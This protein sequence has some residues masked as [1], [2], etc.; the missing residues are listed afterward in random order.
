[1]KRLLIWWEN[2]K[3]LTRTQRGLAGLRAYVGRP[4]MNA[5]ATM[6]PTNTRG[7][8]VELALVQDMQITVNNRLYAHTFPH[9]CAAHIFMYA[10]TARHI[11]TGQSLS[12][13]RC[14]CLIYSLMSL[15][16]ALHFFIIAQQHPK[17]EHGER[18]RATAASRSL[19]VRWLRPSRSGRVRGK[20]K[21]ER[22]HI[23][24]KWV[25]I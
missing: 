24:G 14:C 5:R 13:C 11:C 19:R 25:F 7:G 12:R 17:T 3:E 1:V 2:I 20:V 10:S 6:P 8:G 21:E 23:K 18:E 22:A 16:G 9:L 4:G 15:F